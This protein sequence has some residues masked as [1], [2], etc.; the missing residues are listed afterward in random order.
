MHG[1]RGLSSSVQVTLLFPLAFGVLLL[2]LQWALVSW[3]QATALA[4]AQDGARIVSGV[5]GTPDGGTT[6]AVDAAS[7]GSMSGVGAV[8]TRTATDAAVT[9]NGQALS[10]VP[11]WSPRISQTAT[12]PVERVT[13]S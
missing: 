8:V 13:S 2:A 1:Q 11:G 5:H 6:A 3:A 12:R 7:N 4:A 9:V 10:V